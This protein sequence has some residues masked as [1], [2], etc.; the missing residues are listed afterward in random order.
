VTLRLFLDTIQLFVLIYREGRVGG[1]VAIYTSDSLIVKRR[2]DLE[3]VGS[4]LLWIEF[5]LNQHHFLYCAGYRP[6]NND[7]N[8]I[9]VFFS[10]FQIS[11]DKIRDLP[12][13]FN[14]IIVGDFNAHCNV[15]YT[16]R[17]VLI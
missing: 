15:N 16:R 13:D 9:N 17:K 3:I 2:S 4:E 10:N 1:G 12:R 6:P 7:L 5:R 8:S 11:L 14:L